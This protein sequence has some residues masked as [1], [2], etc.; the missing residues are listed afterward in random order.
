A[1]QS[2]YDCI[3]AGAR[4]STGKPMAT[5]VD[6]ATGSL[7][8]PFNAMLLSPDVGSELV[9]LADIIRFSD[10]SFPQRVAEVVILYTVRLHAAEYPFWS[11]TKLG[12]A[13]GLSDSTIEALR[14][15]KIPQ[16]LQADENAALLLAI[17][18]LGG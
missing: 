5:R 13:A 10:L 15:K 14:R 2:M 1:Q 6:G 18:V 11:H 3:V 17:E 4:D 16:T 7:L 8:G 9:K 12:R